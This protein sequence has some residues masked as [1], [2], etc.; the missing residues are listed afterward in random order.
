M[1]HE[2]SYPI[3]VLILKEAIPQLAIFKDNVVQDLYVNFSD[4]VYR[5]MWIHLDDNMIKE[6]RIWLFL[7]GIQT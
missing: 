6:F 1:N 3:D 2:I 7:D 5:A 4:E